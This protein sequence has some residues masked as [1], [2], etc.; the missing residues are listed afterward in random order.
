MGALDR[1]DEAGYRVDSNVGGARW[2]VSYR[3]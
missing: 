2:T 1:P 3:Y